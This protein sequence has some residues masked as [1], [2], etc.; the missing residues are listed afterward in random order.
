MSIDICYLWFSRATLPA[1]KAKFA[2]LQVEDI[3]L[4]QVKLFDES[5]TNFQEMA[6]NEE[7]DKSKMGEEKL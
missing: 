6:A 7:N 3:Q 2:T 5:K 1:Q 4:F